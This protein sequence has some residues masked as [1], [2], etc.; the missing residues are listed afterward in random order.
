MKFKEQFHFFSLE[1][2]SPIETWKA[3]HP[4][5]IHLLLFL[6][7]EK[8]PCVL[9]VCTNT[10]RERN[11]A[12]RRKLREWDWHLA[13]I[14]PS[15]PWDVIRNIRLK[16]HYVIFIRVRVDGVFMKG[17]NVV[18]MNSDE[19]PIQSIMR[20]AKIHLSKCYCSQCAMY[21][22]RRFTIV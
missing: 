2:D 19:T 20:N 12:I 5:F 7:K 22:Q 10:C 8:N 9:Y 18:S 1:V 3:L 16:W 21:T 15:L 11:P 6:L 13:D 4:K 14:W 17:F